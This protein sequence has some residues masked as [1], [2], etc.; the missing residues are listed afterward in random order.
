LIESASELWHSR[1]Y[2]DVG[3]NEICEHAG[4]R[5]GSFYHF[6]ASKQDLGLAVIDCFWSRAKARLLEPTLDSAQ[7]LERFLRLVDGEYEVQRSLKDSSGT[8]FGCPFGNLAV[9][10]S[11]QDE[12][13]RQRLTE[14]FYELAGYFE[15]ILDDAVA[16]GEI[17][18]QDTRATAI[19]IEAYI[20]G[21][22]LFAK[23][24]N[25]PELIKQLAP[26]ILRLAGATPQL[27]EELVGAQPA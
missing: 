7:P 11:T 3:V 1:S 22:L 6:F 19:A 4:A 21:M 5:K 18:A 17:P 2:A 12:A 14:L 9:E 23:T 10:M 15:R 26:G 8:M 24:A 20:E 27:T 13:L 25:D 16:A